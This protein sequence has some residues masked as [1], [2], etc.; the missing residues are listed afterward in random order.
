M[1]V[2]YNIYCEKMKVD[3]FLHLEPL[4]R[5][6]RFELCCCGKGIFGIVEALLR[7]TMAKKANAPVITG[8][9][10]MHKT[11][12]E[13]LSFVEQLSPEVQGS[14]VSVYL[15]V[16][17]TAIKPLADALGSSQMIVGAQNMNDASEGAFTG[18]IAGM[19]IKE[20]G[21]KFVI[22]GH[23]ERRHLFNESSALINKKVHRALAE[24]LQ[25]V[26]CVGETLEQ[27]ES[28]ERDQKST[29][30]PA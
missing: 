29:R 21:A 24:G 3:F 8:N 15:A 14:A 5:I 20:A 28:G 23:S 22:L 11:V 10:K 7:E 19:M 6:L 18:E 13:S 17:F 9:W 25:P 2:E 30:N 27:Y 12:G 16:P 4:R 1:S 26:V